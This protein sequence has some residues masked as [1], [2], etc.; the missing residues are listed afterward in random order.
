MDETNEHES[1]Q[2]EPEST[3]N[4]DYPSDTVNPIQDDINNDTKLSS[5]VPLLSSQSSSTNQTRN[6]TS[7]VGYNVECSPTTDNQESIKL[8]NSS[9]LNEKQPEMDCLL[10]K[11]RKGMVSNEFIN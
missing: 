2:S 3:V 8:A 9:N 5:N 7:N 1:R 4:V 6:E 10:E 11:L